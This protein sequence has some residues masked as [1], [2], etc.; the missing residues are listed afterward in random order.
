MFTKSEL[1]WIKEL[2]ED[3][4]STMKE[5]NNYAFFKYDKKIF[6]SILKK[7]ENGKK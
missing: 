2:V 3:K 1:D 5:K 7:C 6:E 4:I